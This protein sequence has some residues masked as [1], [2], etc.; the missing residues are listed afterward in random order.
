MADVTSVKCSEMTTRMG[1]L[2]FDMQERLCTAARDGPVENIWAL[3][4]EGADVGRCD[5]NGLTALHH[6]A[7]YGNVE[8]VR[9][10]LELGSNVHARSVKIEGHTELAGVLVETRDILRAL[11]AYGGT[12]LH[13][14]ASRGHA[15]TL[16]LLV[17][18]GGDA[19]AQDANGASPLHDAAFFG[20]VETTRVL[21]EEMGDDV[22]T[23][24]VYGH[25]PL[26][27][28]AMGGRAETVRLLMEMG[29]DVHA[30]GS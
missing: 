16:R 20:H 13:M 18:M 10:I 6:A 21:V 14:A 15:E 29:G 8:T 5:T 3:V 12:A 1:T 17:R 22:H 27:W 28:A 30:Q 7:F 9:V 25:T 23:Q 24:D 26:Y 11:I 2:P 19:L 4:K